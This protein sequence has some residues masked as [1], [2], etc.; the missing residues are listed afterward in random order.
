MNV[1]ETKALEPARARSRRLLASAARVAAAIVALSLSAGIAIPVG[2]V[3]FTLQ[4]LVLGIIVAVM[5][6]GEAVCAVVSYLALG[7]LGAPVFSGGVGGIVRLVGP[8]G[9]FLY[10]FAPAVAVG[11]ALRGRLERTRLPHAASVLAALLAFIAVA[12]FFGWAH[13]VVVGQMEPAA[14]FAVACAPF[15]ACDL[16]KAGMA[17]AVAVSLRAGRARRAK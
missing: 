14:A 5:P 2:P 11:V 13:L 1:S 16:V 15:V 9:G 3:P 12:Y 7:A 6:A 8:S 10:G 17:C 4:I